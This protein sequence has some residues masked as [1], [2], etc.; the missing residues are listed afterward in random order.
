ME[1]L[2]YEVGVRGWRVGESE[3]EGPRTHP[4]SLNPKLSYMVPLPLNH[5]TARKVVES[6]ERSGCF[7]QWHLML[8][9]LGIT[10]DPRKEGISRFLSIF[11]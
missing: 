9:C 3:V 5:I 1:D 11:L 7:V 4:G 2:H 6:S 10:L 8:Y